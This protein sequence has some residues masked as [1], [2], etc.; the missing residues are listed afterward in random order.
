LSMSGT[1]SVVSCEEHFRAHRNPRD[2]GFDPKDSRIAH[3]FAT[4]PLLDPTHLTANRRPTS[5]GYRYAQ[6][7]RRVRALV[8]RSAGS[9]AAR[10]ATRTRSTN[11]RCV[12]PTSAHSLESI[13]HPDPL[14][15]QSCS[16]RC[17]RRFTASLRA[18]RGLGSRSERAFSSRRVVMTRATSDTPVAA[19]HRAARFRARLWQSAETD[20]L[21]IA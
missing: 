10:L 1:R 11:Q 14:R 20:S 3:L 7:S 16:D 21:R 8:T 12:R 6:L 5:C 4:P 9:L 13:G 19:R 2:S 17:G 18:S 15:Y